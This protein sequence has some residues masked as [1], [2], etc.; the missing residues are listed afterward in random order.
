MHDDDQSPESVRQQHV[1]GG[2]GG[3]GDHGYLI[4]QGRVLNSERVY[5]RMQPYIS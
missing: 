1:P 2:G 5:T 3:G 4:F